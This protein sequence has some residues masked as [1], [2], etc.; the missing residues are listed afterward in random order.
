MRGGARAPSHSVHHE[1][2]HFTPEMIRAFEEGVYLE[3]GVLCLPARLRVLGGAVDNAPLEALDY[4]V[5][6]H[7]SPCAWARLLNLNGHPL[8][9]MT[10][11]MMDRLLTAGR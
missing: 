5:G 10:S 11:G 6:V 9:V 4:I 7:P 2:I 1:T 8:W 3:D